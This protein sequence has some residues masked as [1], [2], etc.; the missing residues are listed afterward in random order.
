MFY[1]VDSERH[2]CDSVRHAVYSLV[3]VVFLTLQ[4]KSR[5]MF[6][7]VTVQLVNNLH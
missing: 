5:V 1:H 2:L 6:F 7:I 3:V 4:G